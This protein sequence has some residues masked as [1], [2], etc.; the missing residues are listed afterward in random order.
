VQALS[1]MTSQVDQQFSPP[2]VAP[3]SQYTAFKNNEVA[4]TWDGI[5]QINDLQATDLQ[6]SLAPIPTVGSEPAVWA[7]SHQLVMFRSRQPDDNKLLAGKAFLQ[8]LTENSAAWT[9]AG[10]IPARSDARETPEFLDSPQAAV[11]EG[12][13]AMRFLP[14]VAAVGE[15]QA[16]TLETA[17]ADAVLGRA[18][19][20]DALSAAAERATALME[21]NLQKFE[22]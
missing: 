5:W 18:E 10:M 13:D 2:N 7:N 1:W 3:D 17:V 11:A 20:A 22:R 6:W 21:A 14:S 12:I 9:A 19:P 4:F 15:V 16:Q 8:F